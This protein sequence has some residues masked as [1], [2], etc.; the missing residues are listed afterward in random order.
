MKDA[1]PKFMG[2]PI[3]VNGMGMPEFAIGRARFP[4]VTGEYL[5]T[6][7]KCFARSIGKRCDKCGREKW[8]DAQY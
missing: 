6:C 4:K 8:T 7:P 3:E 2:C 1:K 5:T